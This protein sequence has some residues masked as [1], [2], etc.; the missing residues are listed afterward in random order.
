MCVWLEYLALDASMQVEEKNYFAVMRIILESMRKDWFWDLRT[1]KKYNKAWIENFLNALMATEWG[2]RIA[3]EWRRVSSRVKL[4]CKIIGT[5]IDAGV[6][7]VSYNAIASMLDYPDFTDDSLGI[8]V[9]LGKKEAY[10]KWV[11]EYVKA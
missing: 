5:L 6:L 4:E 2:E 1:D 3:R 10:F 11:C 7:G 8:Y 9:G